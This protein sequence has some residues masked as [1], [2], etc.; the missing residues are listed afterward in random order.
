M[1]KSQGGRPRGKTYE[2]LDDW[3]RDLA[4]AIQPRGEQGRIAEDAGLSTKSVGEIAKG[5]T[6]EA[7]P[8]TLRS[9]SRAANIPLPDNLV[10][11]ALTRRLQRAVRALRKYALDDAAFEALVK[12]F[13]AHAARAEKAAMKHRD[14]AK[15]REA[16][17]AEVLS[18]VPAFTS[19]GH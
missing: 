14:A 3:R 1:A 16:I 17:A 15:E 19:A 4:L 5:K 6:K 11:D 10:D 9:L 2:I 7:S 18:L 13:E 12:G 8:A